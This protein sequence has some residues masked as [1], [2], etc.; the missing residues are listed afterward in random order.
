[1]KGQVM[2]TINTKRERPRYAEKAHLNWM[3]GE[4]YDI[5]NPLRNLLLAASSCFF[6]EPMYYHRD[7]GQRKPN[8]RSSNSSC[9][10]TSDVKRLRET[11]DAIDPQD[12]RGLSPRKLMEKA[13]DAALDYDAEATLQI[14]VD[15]RNR[16]C[17]RTTPQVILVRAAN[18]DSVRGTGLVRRYAPDIIRRADEP[19][20]CL[21]YQLDEYGR[22]RI[23]NSLKKALRD[24]LASF[25]EYQLGKYRMDG[26]LVKTVDVVNLV[27]PVRTEAIDKLVK[28]NLTVSG[29]TWEAIRSAGGSWEEALEVMGHM[30]LLR[31]LRN[32]EQAG[33]DQDLYLNKLVDGVRDG[34]QLPFRYYSAYKACK[35]AGCG[36]VVLDAIEDCLGASIGHAPHFD[37]KVISL[38]DNSGSAWGNCTSSMGTMHI[39]EIANITG[40][41]TAKT[42][43]EGY[44]GIFGDN[45]DIIPVTKHSSMFDVADKCTA[46][47]RRIGGG[48]ENGIWIFWRDAIKEK[49]HYDHVFVYS[50]MQAGHGG[51]F[52]HHPGDYRDYVW[53]NGRHIDVAKLVSTYRQKV[54][55]KV[56]VYLV[57]VAG[58]QD[59]IMPEFYNKTYILGG[60]GDGILRFAAEMAGMQ[61][62]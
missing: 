45:L 37:G 19:S 13:I 8:S 52:G 14:A 38:C 41:I 17:I 54:N 42:A 10:S 60:W 7:S 56:N 29:K 39:A 33:V 43:D 50:D 30:A 26:R 44:V 5:G 11:L 2:G 51:L 20:V 31:N 1:M 58:Y 48:T 27:H 35:N 9:L 22:K 49:V 34:K 21:A 57:Q 40:V 24:Q 36:P 25:N 23:P 61:S 15:L 3:G 59:T 55:P 4:S 12:W 46:S 53:S 47:G 28:G 62:Q 18:H 6:G 16:H 32:L